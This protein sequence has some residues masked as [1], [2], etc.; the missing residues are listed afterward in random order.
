MSTP[1]NSEPDDDD[2]DTVIQNKEEQLERLK[3]ARDMKKERSLSSEGGR[4]DDLT[5]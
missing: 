5:R 3:A 1:S 2:E 4:L